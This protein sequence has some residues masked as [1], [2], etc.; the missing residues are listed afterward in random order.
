MISIQQS[1][2]NI[3]NDT[4]QKSRISKIHS[5]KNTLTQTLGKRWKYDI[6]NLGP[7]LKRNERNWIHGVCAF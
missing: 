2:I 6:F 4:N 3:N 5:H 7:H 1:F